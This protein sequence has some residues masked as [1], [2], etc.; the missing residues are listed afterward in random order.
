M[1]N[2]LSCAAERRHGEPAAKHQL[3]FVMRTVNCVSGLCQ[4]LP[5]MK[6]CT[7]A[8]RQLSRIITE[9]KNWMLPG[10]G[11]EV[12]LPPDIMQDKFV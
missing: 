4:H 10:F 5:H 1:M 2:V 6:Y 9:K 8:L 12:G 3:I 7:D 11:Q